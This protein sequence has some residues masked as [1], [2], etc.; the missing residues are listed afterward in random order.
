MR[1]TMWHGLPPSTVGIRRRR[2]IRT[3][4]GARATAL[5]KVIIDAAME[6]TW[7]A[8]TLFGGLGTGPGATMIVDG[9]VEPTELGHLPCKKGP[10]KAA[11][12]N[13]AGRSA[14][15]RNGGAM[16][17]MSWGD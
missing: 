5:N 15:T 3:G 11:S 8:K 4:T 16:S 10:A 7:A 12:A 6:R 9:I 2:M 14:L 13:R 1:V 17:G